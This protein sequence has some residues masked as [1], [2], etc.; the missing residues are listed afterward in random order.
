M[1]MHNNSIT[2]PNILF[3]D[4][5]HIMHRKKYVCKINSQYYYSICIVYCCY[6]WLCWLV[7][8]SMYYEPLASKVCYLVRLFLL[9]H[10]SCRGVTDV[11]ASFGC[12]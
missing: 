5:H 1:H 6:I 9:L 2:T 7:Q 4:Y 12:I 11:T 3:Y 10:N 8:R